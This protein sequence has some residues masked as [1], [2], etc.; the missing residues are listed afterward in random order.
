MLRAL[1]WAYN[2]GVTRERHR[3]AA[4]LQNAQSRR[5]DEIKRVAEQFGISYRAGNEKGTAKE[6]KIE[7]LKRQ[8]AV[9]QDIVDI[10]DQLFSAEEKYSRGASVMFPDEEI[11]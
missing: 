6:A 11:E 2:L 9:D 4:F 1:K 5:Y 3:I 10:I 8:K 7:A